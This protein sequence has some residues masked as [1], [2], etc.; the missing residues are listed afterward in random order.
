MKF[1]FH[2]SKEL[3]LIV[4]ILVVVV[5]LI[6]IL[7]YY[8]GVT[9]DHTGT[10]LIIL[11]LV[12]V[13]LIICLLRQNRALDIQQARFEA[14]VNNINLGFITTNTSAEVVSINPAAKRLL[15]SDG[16]TASPAIL[17][18]NMSH[19]G[20]VFSQTPRLSDLANKLKGVIDLEFQ[21]KKCLLE[22]KTVAIDNVQFNDLFLHIFITPTVIL[23]DDNLG[24]DLIG[25]VILIEDR[26]N[27]KIA[28]KSRDE[29]F[30]IASHELKTPLSV[31]RS[32]AQMI[33]Q[34]FGERIA[35][36]SILEMVDDIY[37][38]AVNLIG[39]VND[40]LDVSRLEQGKISYQKQNFDLVP[41][42]E[43]SLAELL[44]LASSKK[45]FLAFQKPVTA[46]PFVYA[47]PEKAKQ[48]IINL[49]SNGIKYTD[50]GQVKLE[51]VADSEMVK[52]L[53]E[54]TGKGISAE[55]QKLLFRKFQ[56]ASKNIL[57]RDS[58]QRSTGLGLYIARL[59]VQGMEGEIKLEHSEVGKGSVFSF[60][61][62]VA[63]QE[64]EAPKVA[65][66]VPTKYP[67]NFLQ[68]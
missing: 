41:V 67:A 38:S 51:V 2:N 14:S 21:L 8:F 15:F 24:L 60:T 3:N 68:Q 5:C 64:Q 4:P 61:L 32:N 39:I 11:T 59:L 22:R 33:K 42:I 63:K 54:D 19:H 56:S 27:Q 9:F 18:N 31:I 7:N 40:F 28:D 57:T 58:S 46:M 13:V 1:S 62:P 47:D 49:V 20:P 53:V 65:P 37:S 26:T 43:Q 55:N 6:W 17:R 12:V 30:S 34:Y 44:N 36:R 52:I 45:I 25:A 48:V 29:F 66:P 50:S 10:S 35:D 23:E 16:Q